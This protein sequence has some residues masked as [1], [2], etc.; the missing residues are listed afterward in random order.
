MPPLSIQNS[1]PC[2]LLRVCTIAL[3]SFFKLTIYYYITIEELEFQA[4]GL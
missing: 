2:L 3:T 4:T 1:Q